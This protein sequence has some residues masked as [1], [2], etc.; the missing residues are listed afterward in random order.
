[1]RELFE[2]LDEKHPGCE[3][4]DVKFTVDFRKADD[5][6]V[7]VLDTEMADVVRHSEPM[8]IEDICF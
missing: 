1:M 5:Q 3:V 7:D 8:S 4:L 6:D 2:A